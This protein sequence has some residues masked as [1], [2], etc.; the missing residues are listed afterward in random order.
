MP[1]TEIQSLKHNVHEQC[2]TAVVR[3]QGDIDRKI[4]SYFFTHVV[5]HTHGARQCIINFFFQ[6]FYE[7]CKELGIPEVWDETNEHIIIEVLNRLNF[8]NRGGRKKPNE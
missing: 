4:Y 2:G 6:R 1:K 5:A 3:V 8:K 7:E